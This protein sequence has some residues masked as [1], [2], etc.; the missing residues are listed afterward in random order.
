MR[1]RLILIDKNGM[2]M[3]EHAK[4]VLNI[5]IN[6]AHWAGFRIMLTPT[7]EKTRGVRLP[8]LRMKYVLVLHRASSTGFGIRGLQ[9]QP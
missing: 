4:V 2:V 8:F 7:V 1:E 3:L 5:D 9:V 6:I